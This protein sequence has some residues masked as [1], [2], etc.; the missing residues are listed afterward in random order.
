M[1]PEVIRYA[2]CGSKTAVQVVLLHGDQHLSTR[3]TQGF[4][5]TNKS[6]VW[7]SPFGSVEPYDTGTAALPPRFILKDTEY[8][9]MP[10]G[11]SKR[12]PFYCNHLDRIQIWD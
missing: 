10:L 7:V 11:W 5:L 8:P 3:G 2:I 6:R 4:K 1:P 12:V 9:Q